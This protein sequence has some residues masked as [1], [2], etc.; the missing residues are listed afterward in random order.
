MFPLRANEVPNETPVQVLQPNTKTLT[1][2]IWAA[3]AVL[4]TSILV[5]MVGTAFAAGRT[6]N[7][8]HFLLQSTATAVTDLKNDTVKKDVYE[9]NQDSLTSSLRTISNRLDS[10]DGKLD[11]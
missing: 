10:I 1:I 3:L 8:D 4:G 2:N 7:N 6:F 11:K 5:S 9:A